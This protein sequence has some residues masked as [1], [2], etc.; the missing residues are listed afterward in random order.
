[1]DLEEEEREEEYIY[2]LPDDDEED[3]PYVLIS[4]TPKEVAAILN[5]QEESEADQVA[6][7]NAWNP[8]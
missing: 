4:L 2:A 8:R 6:R 3:R 7:H 1:M 5:A